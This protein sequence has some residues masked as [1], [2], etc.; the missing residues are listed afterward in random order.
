MARIFIYA[1]SPILFLALALGASQIWARG[2]APKQIDINEAQAVLA[3]QPAGLVIV[4]VRTPAEYLQGHLRG[5][6]NLDYTNPAFIDEARTLPKDRPILL[7]CR[8]GTRSAG[9]ASVLQKE[10]FSRLMNMQGGLDA[11]Q[12]AGLPV[13]TGIPATQERAIP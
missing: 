10:G 3:E 6:R 12:R 7:Y 11:W 5:A 4:D 9:A 1:A 8:G 13:E 2:E